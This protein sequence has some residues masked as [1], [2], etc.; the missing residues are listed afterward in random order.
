MMMLVV[1]LILF[2]GTHSVRIV[3]D[4]WRSRQLARIGALPWKAAYAAISL[5]GF[6]LIIWGYG[7]TRDAPVFVWQPPM[8]TNHAAA[9]L[10]LI[11]FVLVTAAY[12]PGSRIKAKIGH[13]MV[14][15]VKVWAFAHLIANGTLADIILFGSFMVWAIL[16]YRAARQRDRAA[17]A[18]PAAGSTKGD[19]TVILIGLLAWALF[20]I[21]LHEVLIGVAPA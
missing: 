5:L 3:A 19:V 13:P 18:A 10:T 6:L 14:V 8:W 11:A 7:A 12:V 20:A 2:L 15:G 4:S 17:S 16:S 9:L 1:G 21:Y